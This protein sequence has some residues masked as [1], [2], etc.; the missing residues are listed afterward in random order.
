MNKKDIICH[1]EKIREDKHKHFVVCG[2]IFLI[3]AVVGGEHFST[4]SAV[5]VLG[6]F[7]LMV[8]DV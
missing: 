8:A 2:S 6:L 4:L 5:E 7:L 1:A 3:V